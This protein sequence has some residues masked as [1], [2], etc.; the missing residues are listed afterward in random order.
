MMQRDKQRKITLRL[1]IASALVVLACMTFMIGDWL[2]E[3]TA[4]PADDPLNPVPEPTAMALLGLAGC[5]L[6]G[7]VR[8]RMRAGG[9]CSFL[10]RPSRMS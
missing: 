5:G 9:P 3:I 7:Y 6:G 4:A 2:V 10:L 8:R 1:G